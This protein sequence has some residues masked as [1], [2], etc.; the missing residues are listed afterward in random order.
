MR[1]VATAGHVDHGK[2]SLVQALTGTDPDR[3]AEEKA[4]GLTIDL[5]FAFTTLPSGTEVGFVDVPGHVKFLKNMLAGVG[6]VDRVLF[7]VSAREGWMPQSEEHL[8]ILELLGVRDGVVVLTNADTVDADSLDGVRN[9]VGARLAL[10]SLQDAATVV[11]DS[12]SGRGIDDVRDA[13]DEVLRRAP[14]APDHGRPRLWVDRVFTARGAGVVVTGTLAGGAVSVHDT[15][16]LARDR[17]R[18]RVR[19]IEAA[20][21]RV[22]RAEPGTRVALNLTGVDR[23][24]LTRGDAVVRPNQWVVTHAVDVAVTRVAGDAAP[25]RARVQVHVGSGEHEATFRALGDGGRYARLEL[26]TAVALAP[27]DRL[28]LRDPGRGL[29]LAGAEVLDVDPLPETRGAAARLALPLAARLLAGRGAV[30]VDDVGRRGGVAGAEADALVAAITSSGAG[31][32]AGDIVIEAPVLADVRE[33][34]R[35]RVRDRE[36]GVD[37]ATLAGD[38]GTDAA[39]LRAAL[40]GDTS[41]VVERGVVRAAATGSAAHTPAAAALL[42]TL[43]ATPWSPPAPADAGLA[44]ALVREGALVDVDGIVF[45]ASALDRARDRLRGYFGTHESLSVAD[46]RDLLGTTRKYAVPLLEHFDREGFTR[47]RGD[48]RVAGPTL[49]KLRQ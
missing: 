31:V 32:L 24:E 37:L 10:S 27:G 4:R 1:V 47:R 9:E 40:D 12:I 17:R 29:T 36:L 25:R 19:A 16:E 46:A 44:R 26:D 34:A 6:A 23:H 43:D 2:S 39:V 5:G 41:I 30:A 13:L 42:A 48:V 18:L 3:L 33:R 15:L 21:Q 8:V 35:A 38:L 49:T 14:P 28:V 7:V 11:C 45:T 22:D 20:H